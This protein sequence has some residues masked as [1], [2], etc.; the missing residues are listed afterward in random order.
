M[1]KR[2]KITKLCSSLAFCLHFFHHL[3]NHPRKCQR[4]ERLLRGLFV[5]AWDI[6]EAGR[7]AAEATPPGY[8]GVSL[9]GP[10][11]CQLHDS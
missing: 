11:V 10:A 5:A 9:P 2:A 8:L 1:A 3:L 7:Y 6:R 4:L